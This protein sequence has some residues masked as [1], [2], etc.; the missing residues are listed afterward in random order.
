MEDQAL[1]GIYILIILATYQICRNLSEQTAAIEKG[2]RAL[3]DA[4]KDQ[5]P[6]KT[7]HDLDD[8]YT[9]LRG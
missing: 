1:W 7:A 4:L 6:S 5:Q 2:N 3:L 8:I 9:L